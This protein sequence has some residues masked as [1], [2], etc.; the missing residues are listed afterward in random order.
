M[1][2]FVYGAL[3]LS[4]AIT[5]AVASEG[6]WLNLD[7]ELE[8][9][10]TLL[11]NH[12][13]PKVGGYII[14]TYRAT[15]EEGGV[16]DMESS[17]FAVEKARVAVK[18]DLGDTGYSYKIQADFASGFI[19]KDAYVTFPVV[20][21]VKA[22]VGQQKLPFLRS[23]L[24]SSAKQFFLDR[25]GGSMGGAG[26]AGLGS[27]W[28]GRQE[29]VVF[30][31]D[32]GEGSGLRWYAGAFDG[33]DGDGTA[34]Q[35]AVRVEFDAM[36][37]GIVGGKGH[38]GSQGASEDGALTLAVAYSSDGGSGGVTGGSAIAL[39]ATWVTNVYSF[40]AEVVSY[41]DED[42]NAT[43][44]SGVN[45][46]PEMGDNGGARMPFSV[47]GTFMLAPGNEDGSDAWEAGLRFETWDTTIDGSDLSR[48]TA[49][50]NHYLLPNHQLKWQF[51][52]RNTMYEADTSE[53]ELQLGVG[54]A[55][56][57]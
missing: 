52:V 51:Q 8:A 14:N 46:I 41:T 30:S 43:S 34:H 39:E 10:P 19:L 31:G 42:D 37:E 35:I 25:S 56:S 45:T 47:F 33:Q 36:G 50:V 49:G 7:Q 24:T 21:G 4:A 55:A 48:L 1:R 15:Q 3:A 9:F 18:G 44:I 6:D 11:D 22:R 40:G 16:E 57:F 28:G 13:G 53:D 29:G 20:A 32:A 5:P 26:N 54:L 2:K 23:G 17:D 38:Q 12:A 27:A